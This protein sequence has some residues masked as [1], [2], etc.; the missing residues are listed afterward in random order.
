MP[1]PASPMHPRLRLSPAGLATAVLFL[2]GPLGTDRLGQALRHEVDELEARGVVRNG[3]LAPWAARLLMLV[4]APDL[5]VEVVVVTSS[6]MVATQV[7]GRPDAALIGRINRRGW[8]DLDPI[9]PESL[10]FTLRD[11][12]GLVDRGDAM[13]AA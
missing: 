1:V 11:T 10:A 4:L 3:V 5:H 9:E 7:W 6:G 8:V 13:H 2:P 12:V